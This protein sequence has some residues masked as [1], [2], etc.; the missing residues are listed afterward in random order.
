MG[1]CMGPSLACLFVGYVER[2]LFRS[3]TGPIP[4]LFL[5]YID[6]CIGAAS[7][8]DE[9]L[10]Q[11]INFTKNFQ[12]NLKFTWIITDTAISFLDL[13]GDRLET[14]IYFKPTDSHSYPGYTH[15]PAIVH[16]FNSPSHSLDDMSILGLLQC[17]NDSTRKLEE[18]HLIF[19]LGSQQPN[20]LNVDFI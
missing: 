1:T 9:E 11:F 15:L 3:Y 16:H 17:H 12:T 13:S 7:C 10:E 8:S 19:L 2:S 4:Y 5:R 18:Q 14:D 6:E 20:G